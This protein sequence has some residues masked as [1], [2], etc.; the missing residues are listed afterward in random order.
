MDNEQKYLEKIREIGHVWVA[1]KRNVALSFVDDEAAIGLPVWSSYSD[2]QEF[3]N[4]FSS[5]SDFSPVEVPLE[6][7]RYS[8]L[9]NDSM[10]IAEVII[11]PNGLSKRNYVLTTTEF[12]NT[13]WH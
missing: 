4:L 12:A 2:A 7:F 9:L 11:S 8:W 13:Y 3:L 5:Y 10:K 1:M 6:T